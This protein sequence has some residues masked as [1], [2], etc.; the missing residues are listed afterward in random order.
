MVTAQVFIFPILAA[1]LPTVAAAESIGPPG[2]AWPVEGNVL[3][4]DDGKRSPAS[5][6]GIDILVPEGTDVRASLAGTVIYAGNGLS[7]LRKPD[8]HQP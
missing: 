8:P 4:N 3:D 7:G 5:A 6:Q 1:V 2:F